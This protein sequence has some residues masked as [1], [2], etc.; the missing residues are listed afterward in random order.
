MTFKIKKI[1]THYLLLIL[2]LIVLNFSVHGQ[3]IFPLTSGF[4]GTVETVYF[5]TT[6]NYFYAGGNFWRLSGLSTPMS[7]I[8]RWNGLNWDSLDSGVNDGQNV[9][10]LN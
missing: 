3:N 2:S 8:S 5:D 6:S 7:H 1:H 9:S 10:A 4:N